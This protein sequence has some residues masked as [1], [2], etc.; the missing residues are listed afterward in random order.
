MVTHPARWSPD[1]LVHVELA[2]NTAHCMW[3]IYIVVANESPSPCVFFLLSFHEHSAHS[4][5]YYIHLIHEW[6]RSRERVLIRIHQTYKS[7][8][9]IVLHHHKASECWTQK[10]EMSQIRC[11]KRTQKRFEVHFGITAIELRL[12]PIEIRSMMRRTANIM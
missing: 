11:T 3:N 8:F 9:M 1:A 12:R 2:A 6:A 7:L 4:R 5:S 10:I